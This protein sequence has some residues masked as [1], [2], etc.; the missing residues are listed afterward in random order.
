MSLM[1]ACW[2]LSAVIS[3]AI[4]LAVHGPQLLLGFLDEREWSQR[5]EPSERHAAFDRLSE[6]L[7]GSQMSGEEFQRL[8]KETME[9][10]SPDE[11]SH[12]IDTLIVLGGDLSTV[13]RLLDEAPINR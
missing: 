11:V 3:A 12:A 1:I 13:A 2:I 9:N 10:M 6:Q 8:V 5:G 4:S 7:G